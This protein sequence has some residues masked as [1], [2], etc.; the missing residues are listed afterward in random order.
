MKNLIGKLIWEFYF[1]MKMENGKYMIYKPKDIIVGVQQYQI[2]KHLLS[3]IKLD[4]EE[5]I[6]K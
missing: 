3:L 2:I 6:L 1:V 5:L 4:Q